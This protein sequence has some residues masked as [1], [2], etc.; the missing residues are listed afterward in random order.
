MNDFIIPNSLNN[1]YSF[2]V[3]FSYDD[4]LVLDL[5]THRVILIGSD[6]SSI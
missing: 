4:A 1:V 5:V 2:S 3:S 6:I